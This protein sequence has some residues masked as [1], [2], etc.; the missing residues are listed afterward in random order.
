MEKIELKDDWEEMCP[1][2]IKEENHYEHIG[3]GVLLSIWGKTYLLTVAHIVDFVYENNQELYLPNNEGHFIKIE[4]KLFHNPLLYNQNRDDDKIDFSYFELSNQ[5]ISNIIKIFKPLV[6]KQICFSTDFSFNTLTNKVR[7]NERKRT[8]TIYKEIR[9][10]LKK[11][12]S[13][14]KEDVKKHNDI[15]IKIIFAGHP[16]N[17]TRKQSGITKGEIVYYYGGAVNQETYKKEDLNE[18]IHLIAEF[19]RAKAYNEN[20]GFSNFPKPQGISGG[21]VYRII[22]TSDGFDRELIGI[23]H[24]YLA[25]KHLFIRY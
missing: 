24:T 12:N 20:I 21:G 2:F 1:I 19:G 5:M 14:S 22:R 9:E 10:G 23:G 13:L 4:G 11:I 6:E 8:S 17:K 3:T 7:N 15:A 18:N 25:K 16:L